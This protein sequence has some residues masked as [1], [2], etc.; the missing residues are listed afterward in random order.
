MKIDSKYLC[1]IGDI[2]GEFFEISTK[3]YNLGLKD[4]CFIILGDCGI[5][6]HRRGYYEQIYP[7]LERRLENYNNV[8]LGFRGNHDDPD[9]FKE[10]GLLDFPRF[11]TIPDFTTLHWNDREIFVI[12]GAISTDK[13]D[14]LEEMM[15]KPKYRYKNQPRCWWPGEGVIQDFSKIPI[16]ADI[17]VS[18]QAPL[19]VGPIVS[20]FDT[21]TTKDYESIIKERKFLSRV[22]EQTNPKK[23]YFGHYHSSTSG[24]WGDTIWKGLS[25]NEIIEVK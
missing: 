25:K 21:M 22:L 14:R 17:I 1:I 12:G 8:I 11:K 13:Q 6:F 9:F 7:K 23:W 20:K 3:I 15:K 4:T 10:G 19:S 5:G 16:K 24:S 18:H 2:H